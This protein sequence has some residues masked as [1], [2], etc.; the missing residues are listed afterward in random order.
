MPFVFFDYPYCQTKWDQQNPFNSLQQATCK[1]TTSMLAAKVS[2]YGYVT[3][4]KNITEIQSALVEYG[5]LSIG[6]NAI[7]SFHYYA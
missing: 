5:P 7:N 1:Y 6:I 2:S 4:T 3:T